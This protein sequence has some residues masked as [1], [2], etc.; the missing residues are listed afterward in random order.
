MLG[1]TRAGD[2]YTMKQFESM[3]ADGGFTQN[4]LEQVPQSPQQ[5]IMSTK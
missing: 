4:R 3:L 2:A 1:T 5:L